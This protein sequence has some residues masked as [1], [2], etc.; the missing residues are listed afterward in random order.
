MGETT[1]NQLKRITD[2]RGTVRLICFTPFI[3]NILLRLL[4]KFSAPNIVFQM[5]S[6]WPK[7]VVSSFSERETKD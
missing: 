6:K 4:K 2:L 3:V 1:I 5:E 7:H